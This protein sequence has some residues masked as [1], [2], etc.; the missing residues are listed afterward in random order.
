MHTL[1]LNFPPFLAIILCHQTLHWGSKILV[2]I[3]ASNLNHNVA[4]L[5]HEDIEDVF[6]YPENKNKNVNIQLCIYTTKP[7]EVVDHGVEQEW[8]MMGRGEELRQGR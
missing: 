3:E 2:L 7:F 4:F 8:N 6:E 1:N 5:S